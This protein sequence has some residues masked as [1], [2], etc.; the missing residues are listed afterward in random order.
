MGR[1]PL[2]AP[3]VPPTLDRPHADERRWSAL[4]LGGCMGLHC[5]RPRSIP[6]AMSTALYTVRCARLDRS[7]LPQR[8]KRGLAASFK[9]YKGTG[10]KE[11][12][13]EFFPKTVKLFSWP[14]MRPP[15]KLRAPL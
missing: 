13:A 7:H 11:L 5:P 8:P 14:K 10:K 1:R 12:F 6:W 9:T 3:E 4:L 2:A 15:T